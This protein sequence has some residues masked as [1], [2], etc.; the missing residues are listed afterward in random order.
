MYPLSTPKLIIR[1]LRNDWKLLLSIFLGIT[2]ATALLAGAP[3]YVDSLE[4]QGIN[5]A[6]DRSSDAY[7]NIFA[8]APHV[9][10]SKGGLEDAEQ[11][12]DSAIRQ[13]LSEV[14]RG[15]QRHVKSSTY[16][17]GLPGSRPPSGFDEGASEGYFQYLSNVEPY[18]T[19]ARGRMATDE[20]LQGPRGPVV[21]AVIGISAARN[22]RLSIGDVVTLFPVP[23]A[24]NRVSA[25]IVGILSATDPSEMY[26]QGQSDVFIYGGFVPQ[27]SETS[28]ETASRTLLSS[29]REQ[30]PLAMLMTEGAMTEGIGHV[31]PG[32]LVSSTWYIASTKS[33]STLSQKSQL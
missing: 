6:I 3:V 19:F 12:L 33:G 2:I 1:R 14:T 31:Y 28:D 5:T 18:V 17:M 25:T 11:I 10:L 16:P 22:F 15:R 27:E 29:N 26:W 7:L 13:N 20:V 24:S 4:R 8:V 32:T 23:G 21:E 30:L 9:S